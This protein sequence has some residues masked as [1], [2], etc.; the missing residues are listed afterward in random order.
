MLGG[1]R[2]LLGMSDHL[3]NGERAAE[4]DEGKDPAFTSKFPP[5]QPQ[6]IDDS[7][8]RL[9]NSSGFIMLLV[10]IH[11]TIHVVFFIPNVGVIS[12]FKVIATLSISENTNYQ[13]TTF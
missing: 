3:Q 8:P 1:S 9:L 4:G 10:S 12:S 2:W 7:L 13:I 11:C 5:L 6:I